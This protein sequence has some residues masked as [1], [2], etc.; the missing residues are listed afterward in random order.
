[1]MMWKYCKRLCLK[2]RE[3]LV[4]GLRLLKRDSVDIKKREVLVSSAMVEVVKVVFSYSFI[5]FNKKILQVIIT[6]NF[7]IDQKSYKNECSINVT[8]QWGRLFLNLQI[9][10]SLF[11]NKSRTPVSLIIYQFCSRGAS[12]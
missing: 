3:I 12:L 10:Q 6:F 9:V 11:K 4:Y 5:V 7:V 8:R 2:T 1:M